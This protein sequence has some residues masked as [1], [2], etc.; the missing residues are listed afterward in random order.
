MTITQSLNVD[1][2]LL[3]TEQRKKYSM[4]LDP[5]HPLYDLMHKKARYKVFWGGRGS[6]KSW[7]VAEALIRIACRRRVRVL[8][9]REFQNSIADSS[10]KLLKDTI[11]RLGLTAFFDVTSNSIKSHIGSEF[12]FKGMHGNDQGIRS[13]EGIDIC[14]VEEAQTVSASSWQALSPTIRKIQDDG[15]TAEIWVTYNL[16][17]EEDATHARFVNVETGEPK[18]TNSIVHKLNFDRNPFFPSSPLYQEMLD[19]KKE[20]QH[21]YEHIWLGMALVMDDS[22]VLNGKY[23]EEEFSDE[24]W[25]EAE[26]LH[27]G[28]DWGYSQ[29]PSA[30]VRCFVITQKFT[31]AEIDVRRQMKYPPEPWRDL[32]VSHEAYAR[33]VELNDYDDFFKPVPDMHDWPVKAD[34]AQP[35]TISH[36]RSTCHLNMEGAEKWA[37]SVED[38]IKFLRGFRR[39]IIHKRCVKTLWEARVWSWKVDK[40]TKEVLPTLVDKNNHAWDAVRYAFDGYIQRGAQKNVWARLAE[41]PGVAPSV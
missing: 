1:D 3:S 40:N 23:V 16:I 15:S 6:A 36:V 2:V 12:I 35:A 5:T 20:S 39:I 8:C 41:Q 13:T 11:E 30:A 17:R 26:R 32:Y 31:D 9:V 7:G 28:V 25:R 33:G 37:G 21:L 22:I 34:C 14:W 38:G 24:M 4:C 18:R 10:H 19:D 27:F 29:D